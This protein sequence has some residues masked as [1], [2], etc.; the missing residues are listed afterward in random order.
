MIVLILKSDVAG[1]GLGEVLWIVWLRMF[2]SETVRLLSTV[3]FIAP[4]LRAAPC[5]LA[6]I[7]WHVE[8]VLSASSAVVAIDELLRSVEEDRVD[9]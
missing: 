8:I 1:V 3:P 5:I 6:G 4:A 9:D 7:V 2:A